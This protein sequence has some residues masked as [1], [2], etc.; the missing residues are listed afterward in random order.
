MQCRRRHQAH[1]L[2]LHEVSAMSTIPDN[3]TEG[4]FLG[5]TYTDEITGELIPE[6]FVKRDWPARRLRIK[7]DIDADGRDELI[8][9]YPRRREAPDIEP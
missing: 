2:L 8:P 6:R 7:Y 9:D 5:R 4:P 1:F 3:G